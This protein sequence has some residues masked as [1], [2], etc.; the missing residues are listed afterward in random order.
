MHKCNLQLE[1]VSLDKLIFQCKVCGNLYIAERE[2]F[3]FG[4]PYVVETHYALGRNMFKIFASARS[5][6]DLPHLNGHFYFTGAF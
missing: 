5:Y 1:R 4:G 2:G 3:Y 6:V